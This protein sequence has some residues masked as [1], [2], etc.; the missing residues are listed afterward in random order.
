[1]PESPVAEAWDALRGAW[2]RSAS[3]LPSGP[4]LRLTLRGTGT[5]RTSLL[6][7]GGFS[8]GQP[9]ELLERV[10]SL[11]AIWHQPHAHRAPVLLAGEQRL[12]ESWQDEELSVGGAVFLQVN[13][14][15]AALLEDHVLRVAGDVGGRTVIDA[16]CGV[17]LH[18]RRL[19]RAGARVSGI[20][21][22]EHAV[23]EARRALPDASFI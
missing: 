18:A 16:Y 21:L 9:D 11:D 17:G 3:R 19:A 20:E 7:Q 12:H 2:G 1:L 15:V 8:D 4:R 22:D 6:V 13:R 23:G 14:R 5:G 10:P